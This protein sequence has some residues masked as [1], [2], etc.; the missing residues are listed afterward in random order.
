MDQPTWPPESSSGPQPAVPV[1][2][3]NATAPMQP[4]AGAPGM[5]VAVSFICPRCHFPVKPEYYFCPNCGVKLTEP[6]IGVGLL[7][8][9]L[10]YAFSII[11]PWIAYLAIT[12]WQGIKYLRS[13]DARAK[14]I[15]LIALILLVASSVVAFWLTY[16]WIEGTVQSSVN[17]VNS[18][19]GG[20]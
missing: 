4:Q 3:P 16:Q 17:A 2:Q 1:P 20:F 9:L 5:G 8:Q 11:L 15:G 10:L 12:K 14:Q 19:L 7:D 6:P 18:N 13:A